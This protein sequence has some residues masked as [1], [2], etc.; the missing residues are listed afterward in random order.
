P[1][2]LNMARRIDRDPTAGAAN[3]AQLRALLAELFPVYADADADALTLL[4][5]SAAFR[6]RG[7]RVSDGVCAFDLGTLA[8]ATRAALVEEMRGRRKPGGVP[9]YAPLPAGER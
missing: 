5:L 7:W 9:A 3:T 4:K 6:R 2:P 1:A 8:P